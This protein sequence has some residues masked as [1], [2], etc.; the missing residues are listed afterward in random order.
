MQSFVSASAHEL[1][2]HDD[3]ESLEEELSSIGGH[4]SPFSG[5][6]DDSPG[7]NNM[8]ALNS[9]KAGRNEEILL[10]SGASTPQRPQ[11]SLNRS[12]R[13]IRSI[14]DFL[15]KKTTAVLSKMRRR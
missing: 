11:S 6:D 7:A 9:S 2:Q 14:G 3:S 15:V 1:D 4:D 5:D 13:S 8:S 10:G 12:V